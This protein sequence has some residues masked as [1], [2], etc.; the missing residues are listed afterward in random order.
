MFEKKKYSNTYWEC[1]KKN[2]YSI[3]TTTTYTVKGKFYYFFEEEKLCINTE[4]VW[5][6]ANIH[7]GPQK[8]PLQLF[9]TDFIDE[10]IEY[11]SA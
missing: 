9:A 2:I 3:K 1:T 11:Y 5:T 6:S 10:D 4:K 8:T 7:L